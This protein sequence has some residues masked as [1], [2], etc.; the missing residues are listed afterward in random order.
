MYTTKKDGKT[1]GKRLSPAQAPLYQAQIERFRTFQGL[2]QRFV[3]LGEQRADRE[4]AERVNGGKK[5]SKI[6]SSGNKR[7]KPRTSSSA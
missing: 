7:S 1:L 5:N 6:T 3:D 2:C 4:V